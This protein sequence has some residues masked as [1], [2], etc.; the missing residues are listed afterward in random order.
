LYGPPPPPTRRARACPACGAEAPSAR[1]RP[2]HLRLTS[3][4]AQTWMAG[5]GPTTTAWQDGRQ[6]PQSTAR[7]APLPQPTAKRAER[8][9]APCPNCPSGQSVAAD[10]LLIF[11][12]RLDISKNQKHHPDIP[13]RS[14]EGAYRPIVTTRGA[15]DAMDALVTRADCFPRG[16]TAL[17]RTAK[18][19]G[20]DTPTLVS[21]C[22]DAIRAAMGAI[23][24]GP[25]GEREEHR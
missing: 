15:R 5:T 22:A 11:E 23:K 13:P 6:C 25:Q 19:C 3:L 12:S 21:S 8:A 18:S 7:C 1:R 14:K 24:P 9:C 17:M 4:A 2:G 10:L 20:P 16:R